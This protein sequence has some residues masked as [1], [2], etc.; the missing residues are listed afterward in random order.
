MPASPANALDEVN[1]I[2]ALLGAR[3]SDRDVLCEL[4]AVRRLMLDPPGLAVIVPFACNNTFS[5]E[6]G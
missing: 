6:A 5:D 1:A 4:S 3:I 2:R